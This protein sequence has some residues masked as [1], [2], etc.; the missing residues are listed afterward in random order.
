[1]KTK[2]IIPISILIIFIISC[3][4][5]QYYLNIQ[6]QKSISALNMSKLDSVELM[7]DNAILI[8]P[9]SRTAMRMFELTQLEA[10]YTVELKQGKGVRFAIRAVSNEYDNH[11]KITFDYTTEGCVIKENGVLRNSVDSVKALPNV[12][13]RVIIHNDGKLIK[14]KVDCTEVYYAKTEIPATEYIVIESIENSVVYISGIWFSDI[15]EG[16]E[17]TEGN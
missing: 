7:A 10:D 12:P 11:P 5:Y 6:Q 1:M 4:P 8:Y 9:G 2:I 14:I 15:L 17:F 16:F 3:N 13:T